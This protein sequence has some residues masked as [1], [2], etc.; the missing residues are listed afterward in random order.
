MAAIMRPAGAPGGLRLDA[1]TPA[2]APAVGRRGLP[3]GGSNRCS[4]HVIEPADDGRARPFPQHEAL[5][6]PHLEGDR[7]PG[8]QE[9][10]V[11]M[12]VSRHIGAMP[13]FWLCV[14]D[15]ATRGYVERNSI[16][17][18]SQLAAGQDPPSPAVTV[19]SGRSADRSRATAMGRRPSFGDRVAFQDV[20]S[21]SVTRK[22]SPSSARTARG[23][24]PW[25]ARRRG[26]D[27]A[28]C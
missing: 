17:L 21:R 6:P 5:T 27:S 23:R 24:R 2:A 19:A 1:M 26:I 7:F 20:S 11:E 10:A 12:A 3:H 25:C 15:P 4:Q 9:T 8:R 28:A 13:V 18:T 22:C 14:P 16:A